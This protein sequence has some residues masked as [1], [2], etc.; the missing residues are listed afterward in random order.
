LGPERFILKCL[1][2]NSR[3]RTHIGM[4]KRSTYFDEAVT[5]EQ[6]SRTLDAK[7]NLQHSLATARSAAGTTLPTQ[8]YRK[9]AQQVERTK[10]VFEGFVAAENSAELAG[11][12]SKARLPS[13]TDRGSD[14]SVRSRFLAE[15]VGVRFGCAQAAL[16]P[17]RGAFAKLPKRGAF[18]KGPLPFHAGRRAFRVCA[19]SFAAEARGL[20]EGPLKTRTPPFA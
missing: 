15:P 2:R 20:C 7:A 3:L 5:T 4:A 12:G 6:D 19:G 18:A 14:I 17:K 16:L 10:S 1:P 9:V 11:L 13:E 8:R